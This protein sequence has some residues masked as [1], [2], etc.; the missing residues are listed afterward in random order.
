MLIYSPSLVHAAMGGDNDSNNKVNLYKEAKDLVL[1][2]K[3]LEKKNKTDKALKGANLTRRR[4]ISIL[5]KI[6]DGLGLSP[7]ELM[8]YTKRVKRDI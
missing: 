3:K 7:R 4:Q 1:R 2:A 6:V 5:Y 8:R